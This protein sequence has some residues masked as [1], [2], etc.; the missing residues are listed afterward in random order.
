VLLG[1]AAVILHGSK[2]SGA[3]CIGR[4][5][6]AARPSTFSSL[7]SRTRL[8]QSA[9]WPKRWGGRTI[10]RRVSST[11]TVTPRTP[12]AVAQLKARGALAEDCRHRP[13]P[14]VVF[15]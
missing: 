2:A 11:P 1:G 12:P 6:P 8:Q 14:Y 4:W 9:S 10:P 13:V 7:P 15:S 5:T 3:T